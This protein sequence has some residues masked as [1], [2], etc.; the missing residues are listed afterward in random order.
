M[1]LMSVAS[2]RSAMSSPPDLRLASRT[3]GV[4]D[5]QIDD[6]V[7]MDV[8][9]VPVVREF[10]DHDAVL[11]HA[12][13]ELV[14]PGA[15]RLKSEAVACLLGGLGGEHHAGAVGELGDQRRVRRLERDPDGERID[16]L[17]HGRFAAISGL[18]NEP[19]KLRWRSSEDFAASA[20]SFS[21][22]WNL[23][24]GRSLMVDG[25]AVGRGLVRE[26]ELAAPR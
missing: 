3:G 16:H 20:S 7:D 21:P 11:L 15:D 4:D 10:L 9:L 12:L 25:P 17:E 22:S 2:M 18:R 24:F 14:G 5:R 23:T 8:G 26:R 1:S 19:G 13:D 6:A